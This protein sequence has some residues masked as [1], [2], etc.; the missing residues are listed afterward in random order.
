MR[1]SRPNLNLIIDILALVSAVFL[2]VT[3]FLLE[4]T[5]PPGSGRLGT[6]GFGPAPGGPQRPILLLWSLSRHEWGNIHYWIAVSLMAVLSL[7]L[8]L[9]W[10]WIVAMAKGKPREGSGIRL[11]LGILGLASL[12]ALALA[13]FLSST[14]RM[15]R[16]RVLEQRQLTSPLK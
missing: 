15:P 4:Y 14:V 10:K 5:L 13:P 12:L 6:E 16:G 7:H 9:H 2:I 11:A 3:G 1:L 8:V